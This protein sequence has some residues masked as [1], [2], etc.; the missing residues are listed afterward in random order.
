VRVIPVIDVMGGAVVRGVAGRRAEYRPIESRLVSSC[1]PVRVAQAFVALE[2]DRIYLADLDAIGGAADRTEP[3][4]ACYRTLLD[5]GVKLWVDAG[6][7]DE[8]A[9]EALA[10]FAHRGRT[11][12]GVIVA[13]ETLRDPG[14]LSR[15][16]E[17]VGEERLVFSLDLREGRLV[18]QRDAWRGYSPLNCAETALA[19][20]VARIIVL[21]IAA[22]GVGDGVP[23]VE[24]CRELRRRSATL[25]IVSGG[26]I[27][28]IDDLLSLADAG[29]DGAL[30]AS[31]LHDG[32]LT[33]ADLE[34]VAEIRR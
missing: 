33:A 34:S 7:A 22:V 11:I 23:T 2:L 31:A 4:W 19:A 26:G 17:A 6:I 18:S 5:A 15:C 14:M 24:L 32:R 13:L 25:E 27:R 20:G 10:R 29:C 9:A 12:D 3:G 28:G 8:Q 21:D 16:V 30:V 1:E